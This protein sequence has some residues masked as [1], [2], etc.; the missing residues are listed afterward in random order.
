MITNM[1]YCVSFAWFGGACTFVFI[2]G[3][4]CLCVC[5]MGVFYL[6]YMYLLTYC[7]T[8]SI[9]GTIDSINDF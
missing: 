2:L 9:N 6:K 3:C 4:K 5:T 7:T 8:Q 1:F